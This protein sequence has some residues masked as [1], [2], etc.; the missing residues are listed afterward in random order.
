MAAVTQSRFGRR[1]LSK[2]RATSAAIA[3]ALAIVPT[4]ASADTLSNTMIARLRVDTSCRVFTEPLAFGNVNIFSGQVD[5]TAS[6]RLVCGP[7]V[8]YSVAIDNG[9]Y[10]NGQ[11]RMFSGGAFLNY[12]NYE[13]YRN[14]ARTQ[15]W[16]ATPGTVVTGVTPANGRATLTA[17]GRV[18]NSIV[19]P[20]DYIDTVTVTVTF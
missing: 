6:I 4:T 15:V 3:A 8:A 16:G 20:R 14:A 9:Q 17:Y 2:V 10:F 13:I 19:L 12:V 7:A 18:P 5:A 1:L 11:R